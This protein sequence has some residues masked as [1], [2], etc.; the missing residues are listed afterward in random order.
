M[1]Y[2]MTFTCLQAGPAL[3]QFTK[4]IACP[5]GHFE[6]LESLQDL[7]L[8]MS[9]LKRLRIHVGDRD[10][11]LAWI[12]NLLLIW[13][14]SINTNESAGKKQGNSLPTWYHPELMRKQLYCMNLW[15]RTRSLC[16]CNPSWA[17]T[18]EISVTEIEPVGCTKA[19]CAKVIPYLDAN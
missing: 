10:S 6:R 2:Q 16:L 18:K 13:S 7:L 12:G 15:A 1:C 17:A 11:R 14:S 8:E 4:W 5:Q 9:R 3:V 19:N